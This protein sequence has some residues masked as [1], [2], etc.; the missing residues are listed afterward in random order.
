MLFVVWKGH[1]RTDERKMAEQ[2]VKYQRILADVLEVAPAQGG[3]LHIDAR[4]QDDSDVVGGGLLTQG[5]A[6]ALDE[7]G[8][9]GGAQR[10]G[11]REAGGGHR[12]VEA[13]VVGVARLLAQPVGAV[14]FSM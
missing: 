6:H 13:Q 14:V 7:L 9:P 5:P 3:A 2:L 10:R 1:F 11:G 12:S 4:A 8:V